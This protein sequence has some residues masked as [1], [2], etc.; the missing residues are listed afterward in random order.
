ML[1][2]GRRVVARRVGVEQGSKSCQDMAKSHSV[3]EDAGIIQL[4]RIQKQ[5]SLIVRESVGQDGEVR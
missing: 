2:E 5:L 1:L 4:P 3:I